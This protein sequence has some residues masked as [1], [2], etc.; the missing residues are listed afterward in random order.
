MIKNIHKKFIILDGCVI[1]CEHIAFLEAQSDNKLHIGLLDM[2]KF[3][4]AYDSNEHRDA[5][6]D[7]IVKCL[8]AS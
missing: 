2:T 1:N 8:M 4:C 3:T 5:D 7:A 6:Y